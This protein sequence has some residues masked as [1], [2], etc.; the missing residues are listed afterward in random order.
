MWCDLCFVCRILLDLKRKLSWEL[1]ICKFTPYLQKWSNLTG[2]FFKMGWNHLYY[3]RK[4]WK[5]LGNDL[6]F[7]FTYEWDIYQGYSPQIPNFWSNLPKRDITLCTRKDD[8]P[9]R[10][11]TLPRWNWHLGPRVAFS[12]TI[13][14]AGWMLRHNWVVVSNT[15]CFNFH[16]YL[17]KWFHLTSMFEMGWN[18]PP[19]RCCNSCH[20]KL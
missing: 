14:G 3:R 6:L 11:L 4:L 2:I 10:L 5:C 13:W 8:D 7:S 19:T 20:C 18:F 16:T 9:L 17:G 15:V 1:D 12:D